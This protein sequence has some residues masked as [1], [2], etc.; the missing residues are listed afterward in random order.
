MSNEKFN[1]ESGTVNSSHAIKMLWLPP[2]TY[3][4][5]VV[6][7]EQDVHEQGYDIVVLTFEVIE[8]KY[9]GKTCKKRYHLSTKTAADFLS[10]EFERLGVSI[11]DR[12]ELLS[13]A[14]DVMDLEATIKVVSVKGSTVIF[15][16]GP[17][18]SDTPKPTVDPNSVWG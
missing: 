17:R 14:V 11:A 5:R 1:D 7:V 2:G 12:G 15:I 3:S 8:G 18:K 6:D 10:M 4:V 13:K 16:A 9:E